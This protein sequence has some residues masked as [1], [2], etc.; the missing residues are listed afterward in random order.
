MSATPYTG[1]ELVQ[2]GRNILRGLSVVPEVI[3]R[4][5][6]REVC[7][8]VLAR[9][10]EGRAG[11]LRRPVFL[12][13]GGSRSRGNRRQSL[14]YG[15]FFDFNKAAPGKRSLV[16]PMPP[17]LEHVIDRLMGHPSVGS[18]VLGGRPDQVIV[19]YYQPGDCIPPHTDH[20][21]YLRPIVSLS[22][23]SEQPMLLGTP[24]GFK[25]TGASQFT[26]LPGRAISVPCPR[27][28]LVVLDKESGDV[29]QHCVPACTKP[30]ISL[31]F[32]REPQERSTVCGV[33]GVA[34]KDETHS[35]SNI[36]VSDEAMLQSLPPALL[37]RKKKKQ[38]EQQE[39]EVHKEQGNS[40]QLMIKRKPQPAEPG[41]V[42]GRDTSTWTDATGRKRNR[43]KSSK[44]PQAREPKRRKSTSGRNCGD[45][46]WSL[47]GTE[48]KFA[49]IQAMFDTLK[50]PKKKGNK[51]REK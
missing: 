8:W 37:P 50:A 34:T 12:R 21:S 5:E 20:A 4:E 38:E 22:M 15:G 19:N 13:A 27:R 10:A 17:I 31:T 25:C 33:A 29:A 9:C 43:I 14:Q 44:A 7:R 41:H 49:G 28:S 2:N 51:R 16:P 39:R 23:L 3:S 1:F 11:K 48:R 45:K 35:P 36:I 18:K 30:R 6:E 40:Q 47:S 46:T 42:V 24:K 32:R 26:A